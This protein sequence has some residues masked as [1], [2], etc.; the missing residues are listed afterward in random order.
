MIKFSKQTAFFLCFVLCAWVAG[1]AGPVST[2]TPTAQNPRGIIFVEVEGFKV[3]A[4]EIC[5]MLYSGPDG[6]PFK[7][8]KAFKT[9]RIQVVGKKVQVV[10]TDIGYG[11]YALS[12]Y[13]DENKNG[14]LDTIWFGPPSE[15]VG[16]SNNAKGFMGPPS[17]KDASF[18]HNATET[19]Q[20][21]RVVHIF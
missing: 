4:G 7:P 20:S 16:S 15:G 9:K 8:E 11:T 13:H 1:G 21:I 10:F 12:V 19:R 2:P 3:E 18:I 17:F 14:K 6:F 5:A